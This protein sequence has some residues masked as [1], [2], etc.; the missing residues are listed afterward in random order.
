MCNF[1]G[2]GQVLAFPNT[3]HVKI[4]MK[5]LRLCALFL[6]LIS[7]GFFWAEC[8]AQSLYEID[9]RD[10][11]SVLGAVFHAAR[12]G[13]FN[14]LRGLC[15][16]LG[17]GDGDTQRLCG[18]VSLHAERLAQGSEDKASAEVVLQFTQAF[19]DARVT[20]KPVILPAN[21]GVRIAQV[22]FVFGP[23]GE[24]KEQMRLVERY[25]NWYL[26]IF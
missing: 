1:E 15:D 26:Y 9:F 22:D 11:A 8:R 19:R 12:E 13:D 3:I 18:E 14:I 16:P 21:E 7:G 24:R 6:M 5:N 10:P 4:P 20:G 23:G 17:Q 25:G 2:I